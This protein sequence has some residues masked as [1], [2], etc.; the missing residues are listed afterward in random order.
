MEISMDKITKMDF[1]KEN[2]KLILTS[3]I[4]FCT[5]MTLLFFG[6]VY[7]KM[8][9]DIG[10]YIANDLNNG[11]PLSKYEFFVVSF[12]NGGFVQPVS[13]SASIVLS[14]I[15]L[16]CLYLIPYIWI[17]KDSENGYTYIF[18]LDYW[19]TFFLLKKE[20]RKLTEE[21]YAELQKLKNM[22]KKKALSK[23]ANK[24]DEESSKKRA[25]S[26]II[27]R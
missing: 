16:I 27:K 24:D 1:I 23:I 10:S 25:L 20:S 15:G 9:M 7:N 26:K 18:T 6:L 22:N 5:S 12:Y 13:T 14:V 3:F 17:N 11:A 8:Y 19:S 4:L 21:E 2:Y